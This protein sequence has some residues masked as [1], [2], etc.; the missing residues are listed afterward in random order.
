MSVQRASRKERVRIPEM[1]PG[2]EPWSG[3]MGVKRVNGT[4]NTPWTLG[5]VLGAECYAFHS[6]AS[7][8]HSNIRCW[9]Q[10]IDKWQLTV[11]RWLT[12]SA[13]K[14]GALKNPCLQWARLSLGSKEV[15]TRKWEA[16]LFIIYTFH[17]LFALRIFFIRFVCYWT[18]I[19]EHRDWLYYLVNRLI[20]T[21]HPACT[22][23]CDRRGVIN[24]YKV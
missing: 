17:M 15:H 14:I 10:N 20:L 9:V 6:P 18:S 19:W 11:V 1:V 2:L 8:H 3:G 13:A 21:K 16:E 22:R 7:P 4:G 5:A 12:A 23:H 24:L